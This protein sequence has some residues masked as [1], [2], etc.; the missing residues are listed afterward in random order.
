M[1]DSSFLVLVKGV[2]RPLEF[3]QPEKAIR[4]V[5]AISAEHDIGME[6]LPACFA[7]HFDGDLELISELISI[8]LYHFGIP[9][10][11]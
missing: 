9:A 4:V 5:P 7:L 2:I 11:G 6:S 1:L 10:H 8:A 3:H